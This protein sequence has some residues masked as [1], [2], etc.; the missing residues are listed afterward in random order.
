VIFN[1][2]LRTPITKALGV[3][4]FIDAG[5]V[6][7]RTTDID[8]GELRSSAG[9]GVRYKSPVGPIRIDLGFKLGRHVV[10]GVREPLT[11]LHL[12]LGQAF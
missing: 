8:L 2:E 5:N 12:S 7:A 10:G 4:G 3:V 6:F 1:V 9:F 11:A